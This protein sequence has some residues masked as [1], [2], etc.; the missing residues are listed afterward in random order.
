MECVVRLFQ[1]DLLPSAVLLME[2]DD[3]AAATARLPR[4]S[5][6]RRSSTASLISRAFSRCPVSG[7]KLWVCIWEGCTAAR[8]VVGML[9]AVL[10]CLQLTEQIASSTPR[11][12]DLP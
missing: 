8:A 5:A 3:P 1:L 11:T 10:L 12:C 6:A 7:T 2:S 4:P 9:R